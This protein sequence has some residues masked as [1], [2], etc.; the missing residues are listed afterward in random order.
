M[1]EENSS[2][3]D[4]LVAVIQSF[5]S[6]QQ[7]GQSSW[8]AGAIVAII[9]L[10][11]VAIFAW[12]QWRAGK[13]RAKLLHEQAVREEQMHQAQVDAS[14]DEDQAV[15]EESIR[16]ANELVKE[17]ARLQEE[18]DKLEAK[19]ERARATIDKISSWEDVD[20]IVQ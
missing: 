19:R 10:V 6:K 17:V 3:L 12:Q 2:T 5:K 20:A 13:E 1:A 14:L 16:H 8:V 4:K 9:A 18:A 15:K 11:T 7:A